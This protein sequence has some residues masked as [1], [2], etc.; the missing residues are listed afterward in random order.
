MKIELDGVKGENASLWR[1]RG[2]VAEKIEASEA[3]VGSALKAVAELA[4]HNVAQAEQSV[5]AAFTIYWK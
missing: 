2:N 4:E 1:S 5:D 3:D